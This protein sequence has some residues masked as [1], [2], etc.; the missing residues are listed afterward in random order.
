MERSRG[1][2]T[3]LRGGEEEGEGERNQP[4]W[5]HWEEQPVQ[6]GRLNKLKKNKRNTF[7]FFLGEKVKVNMSF[8][9]GN[10]TYKEGEHLPCSSKTWCQWDR[11]K[12][13]TSPPK[14]NEPKVIRFNSNY[15]KLEMFLYER[16]SFREQYLYTWAQPNQPEWTLFIWISSLFFERWET[17][18]NMPILDL[19][20]YSFVVRSKDLCHTYVV[21][22]RHKIW[23]KHSF[24]WWILIG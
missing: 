6:G 24:E 2:E 11:E 12:T 7:T 13:N 19:A 20:K 14:T 9:R 18:V 1:G 3:T 15:F 4:L 5:Q 21:P 16:P 10:N 23:D 8:L 22:L 17:K